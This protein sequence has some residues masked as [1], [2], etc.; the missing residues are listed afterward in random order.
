[1]S[2]VT[3]VKRCD[4]CHAYG[5][6]IVAYPP[7]RRLVR[8]QIGGDIYCKHML[9]DTRCGALRRVPHPLVFKGAGFFPF[10]IPCLIFLDSI[11]Y[12]MVIYTVNYERPDGYGRS[13]LFDNR[14]ARRQSIV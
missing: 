2:T 5:L 7:I 9:L 3:E 8:M 1:M 6:A 10:E 14:I 12:H 13:P 11:D 4:K